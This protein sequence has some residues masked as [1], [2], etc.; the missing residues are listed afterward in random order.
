MDQLEHVAR[1]RSHRFELK[2]ERESDRRRQLRGWNMLD[3][4]GRAQG[5]VQR[6]ADRISRGIGRRVDAAASAYSRWDERNIRRSNMRNAERIRTE[7]YDVRPNFGRASVRQSRAQE[8]AWGQARASGVGI[9]NRW[10]G[11]TA[12]VGRDLRGRTGPERPAAPVNTIDQ[13]PGEYTPPP[14]RARGTL[15]RRD[16]IEILRRDRA[17]RRGGN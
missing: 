7:G 13:L 6:E 5:R 10:R 16:E 8:A 2:Q 12:Q 9:S 14:A 15:T 11:A 1:V 3:T 17:R 4:A